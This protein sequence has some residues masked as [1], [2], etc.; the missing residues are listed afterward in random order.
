[1]IGT[2]TSGGFGPTL[3]G[4]MA[5][6]LIDVDADSISAICVTHEHDDHRASLGI[7]QRSL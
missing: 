7:L 6:G 5:L 4:P 1:M 3:E 2:V